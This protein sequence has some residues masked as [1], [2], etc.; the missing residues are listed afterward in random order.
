MAHSRGRLRPPFF[1]AL[2]AALL[3][4]ALAGCAR[5]PAES[6]PGEVTGTVAYRERIALPAESELSVTLYE[7]TGAAAEPRFVAAQLVPRP[8]QPPLRFRVAYPPGVIDARA[9]YT[10]IA[11]IEVGGTL[12]AVNERPVPVLTFGNPV[13]ADIVVTRTGKGEAPTRAP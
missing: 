8:G 7:T 2:A 3:S 12:W 6:F 4:G 9:G 11:R 10:L 1:F 13:R 5:K